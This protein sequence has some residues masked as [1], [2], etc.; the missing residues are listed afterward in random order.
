MRLNNYSKAACLLGMMVVVFAG[1]IY[2]GNQIGSVKPPPNSLPA[3][4]IMGQD[5]LPA[6]A[7]KAKVASP[8]VKA[9]LPKAAVPPKKKEVALLKP[10]IS[11]KRLTTVSYS[12][13]I[14]FDLTVDTTNLKKK[15]RAVKGLLVFEDLFGAEQFKI[16]YTIN[17][18]LTP[19]IEHSVKGI[20]FSYNQYIA[21][22]QW[23]LQTDISD[24]VCKFQVTNVIYADGT[25]E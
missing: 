20:G 22:H 10:S 4:I 21:S 25:K 19:N 12:D 15:T 11:N 9:S 24:M 23:M 7:A 2:C 14:W 8:R 1:G 5:A 18:P 16:G 17:E 6:V 3:E 13:S